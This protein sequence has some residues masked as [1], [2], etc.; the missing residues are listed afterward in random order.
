MA[1]KLG[2]DNDV[3]LA[4]EGADTIPMPVHTSVS[5]TVVGYAWYL[6]QWVQPNPLLPALFP[7]SGWQ[8]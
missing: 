6:P 2:S 7:A 3:Q 8:C 1:E 5:L 4:G